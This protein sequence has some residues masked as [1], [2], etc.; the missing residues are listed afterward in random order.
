MLREGK[1]GWEVLA[2][3]F[4]EVV[5]VYCGGIE[6]TIISCVDRTAA[7]AAIGEERG[8]WGGSVE[9]TYVLFTVH[10]RRGETS[11]GNKICTLMRRHISLSK[12]CQIRDLS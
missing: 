5:V 8:G 9:G 1:I 12:K 3:V 2:H 11:V 6:L 7:A 4:I 10:S